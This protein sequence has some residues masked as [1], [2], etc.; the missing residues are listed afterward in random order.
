MEVQSIAEAASFAVGDRVNWTHVPRG[1]YGF[2]QSVAGIVR[3]IGQKRI[4]IEVKF[5][6]PYGRNQLWQSDLKWVD[7]QH[8]KPRLFPCEAHGEPL[9]LDI[10]GFVLTPWKHP[11]GY[12]TYFKNG[13]FYGA[14]D[15][16]TCT[17]PSTTAERA[18]QSAHHAL[19]EGGYR[20]SM[21]DHINCY[22]GWFAQGAVAPGKVAEVNG[23][24]RDGRLRLLKLY[25]AYPDQRRD[26]DPSIGEL[27]SLTGGLN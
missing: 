4:Q 26:G 10:N 23:K 20:A 18:L 8:L 3:K 27:E 1:G 6:P 15:G 7:P 5:K 13:T 2:A 11:H 21:L 16:Y 12:S 22:L 14:V 24:I 17:A 19:T 9:Q 25:R